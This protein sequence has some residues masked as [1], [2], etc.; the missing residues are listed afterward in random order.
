MLHIIRIS[1]VFTF[2]I[3]KIYIYVG[4]LSPNVILIHFKKEFKF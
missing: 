2:L 4:I 3:T 1:I